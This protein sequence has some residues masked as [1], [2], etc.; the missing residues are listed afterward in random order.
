M[1]NAPDPLD[2]L[3]GEA[4]EL[5][6]ADIQREQRWLAP[7][8]AAVIEEAHARDPKR[9]SKEALAEAQGLAPVVGLRSDTAM[10][11][12]SRDQAEFSALLAE[13]RADI[14]LDVA[15]QRDL[16]PP[17]M[18]VPADR[19]NGARWL[20][21]IV[22]AAALA[23][24]AFGLRPLL[25]LRDDTPATSAIQAPFHDQDA[26]PRYEA[27]PGEPEPATRRSGRT[28]APTPEPLPEPTPEP[29][30]QSEVPVP[31]VMP[32]V[33]KARTRSRPAGESLA[34]RLR[35]L[36]AEAEAMWQGGDL[37]GAESRY[38]EIVALAPGG[39]AADLAY[40]DLFSL[41]RQRHGADQE[42]ALWREY[43]KSFPRGRYAD[44]ARAGLCRRAEGET[45]GGCWEAYLRDFPDGVHRRQAERVR[46][47]TE[48]D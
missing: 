43:L 40:G 34:D 42:A 46:G 44:D 28:A 48:G 7:D 1:T 36:D 45:R 10:R 23:A 22:A 14:D 6:A 29:T 24:L 35:R 39:R 21:W 8:F 33:P 41:A 3:V 37:A 12:S 17:P 31:E 30:A 27:L 26:S 32:D 38:R 18:A 15:V 20:A 4:T 5:L 9:V 47:D 16:G 19:R 25:T 13:A 11:L 2:R